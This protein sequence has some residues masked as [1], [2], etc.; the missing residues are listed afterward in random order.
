MFVDYYAI[1][2]LDFPSSLDEIKKS[3]RRLSLK[4]HPDRHQNVDT[5]K[6]MVEIN[7]AYFVLKD[8]E[9]KS[10]YDTEYILFK[11]FE[12]KEYNS[13]NHSNPTDKTYYK[14]S[15]SSQSASTS[16][17]TQHT[18]NFYNSRVEDDIKEA[19]DFAKK[20][21]D[22]FIKEFKASSKRAAKGAWEEMWP[23]LIVVIILPIIFSLIRL[24]Q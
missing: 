17:H 21:V 7:E 9:K 5:T 22:E 11:R 6:K 8:S 12:Y 2:E 14:K 13:T 3:Y 10:R 4:W 20:L 19:H 15:S 1:L 18:Y 24:C 23:Y 16:T